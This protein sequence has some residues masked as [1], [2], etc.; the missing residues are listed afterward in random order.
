MEDDMAQTGNLTLRQ[1]ATRLQVS[2]R[3]VLELMSAGTIKGLKVGS[4][5]RFR[6]EDID[7]Y[8]NS[9]A[10]QHESPQNPE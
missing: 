7:A 2:D 6:V 1:V 10:T 5:W 4:Q 9:L 8:L 3:T